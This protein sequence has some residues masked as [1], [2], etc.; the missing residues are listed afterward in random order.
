MLLPRTARPLHRYFNCLLPITLL[1]FLA[2]PGYAEDSADNSDKAA[3]SEAKG[4][5]SDKKTDKEV[6]EAS[7]YG[8]G[9][10]GEETA[11]GEIFNQNKL[12]AA[13]RRLPLGTKAKVTNLENG[14][15]VEVKINDR[16]PYVGG[17]DMDLSRAAAQK[18]DMKEDGTAKVKIEAKPEQN[19]DTDNSAGAAK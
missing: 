14:K 4:E 10:N 12:T 7:W 6:G 15:K 9:F 8:P 3:S 2:L 19:K 16:G 1:S 18:L 5:G 17:R 13:H 11:S